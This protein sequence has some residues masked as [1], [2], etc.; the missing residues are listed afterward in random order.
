MKQDHGETVLV[1][2]SRALG[3]A[4]NCKLTVRCPH[5]TDVDY[6]EEMVKQV[7]IASM[8]D[9]EIK[10]KVLSTVG[11][12]DK[13]LNETVGIIETEEMAS[14]SMLVASESSQA[15]ATS[16]KK[17]ILPSDKRLK[18][19]GICATCRSEFLKHRIKKGGIDKEYVLLTD[20][21]CKPCWQ[22]RPEKRTST[23]QPSTQT[24]KA[25]PVD[26]QQLMNFH[27]LLQ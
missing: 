26:F 18:L 21:H 3:K 11:I 14:R 8:Y 22:K 6:S 2:S 19:K 5:N 17:Q 1:F 20:T 24:E 12:D 23:G 4:R 13:S 7:V 15:G 27:T 25:R 16:F 10:R 9:E